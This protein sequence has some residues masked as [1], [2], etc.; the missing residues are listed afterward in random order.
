LGL[1]ESLV[2]NLP[3]DRRIGIDTPIFIYHFEKS[4]PFASLAGAALLAVE[5]GEVTGVTSL[6]T[7]LE[8]SVLPLRL[9][10]PEIADAYETLI[11]SIPNL[12]IAQI[13]RRIARI[14]AELR[15][16]YNL[17]VPDALQI[18]ACLSNGADTFLTND[19]R[20]RVVSELDVRILADFK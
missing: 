19:R 3:R 5:H 10:R 4:N 14:A 6:V 12:T 1:P 9:G 7:L 15:A 8:I 11:A 20:L 17:R 18:A 16:R 2:S 13:D